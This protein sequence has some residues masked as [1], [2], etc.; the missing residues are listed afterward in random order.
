M[1]KRVLKNPVAFTRTQ[2]KLFQFSGR[3]AVP[4]ESAFTQKAPGIFLARA[5]HSQLRLETSFSRKKTN[6]APFTGRP[7]PS[8]KILMAGFGRD[9]FLSK[10]R[11]FL[12][13]RPVRSS[14]LPVF[15]DPSM[16]ARV[17]RLPSKEGGWGSL[18]RF[19]QWPQTKKHD[20][21]R[22]IPPAITREEILRV[23]RLLCGQKIFIL[24]FILESGF[25]R[26]DSHLPLVFDREGQY[27]S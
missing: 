17:F 10:E 9:R 4:S 7:S 11:A 23:F 19:T 16:G 6:S 21:T 18:F 12:L 8:D 24:G 15:P 26:L 22:S 2:A 14:P 3:T 1:G 27:A 25:R 20:K 5:N 13:K